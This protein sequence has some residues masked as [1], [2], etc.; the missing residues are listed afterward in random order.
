MKLKDATL[1]R[2]QCF[3]DGTWVDADDRRTLEVTN[4]A[5]GAKL[6]TV[7]HMS[8]AET[9]R[10]IDAAARAQPAWAARTA[11]DRA[12]ILRRWS[13][14]MLANQD[15]LATLMTAEQGKPLAESRARSPT[16]PRSSSGSAR[17]PNGSTAT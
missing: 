9:R 1:L 10:A 14:L 3:I 6:G 11:K 2:Q 5:S 15:D 4:P 13:E 16:R 8:A 17:R 12:N 7:P